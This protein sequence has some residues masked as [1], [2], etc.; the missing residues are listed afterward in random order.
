MR[1]AGTRH[2]QSELLVVHEA[3]EGEE[4]WTDL[5]DLLLRV[6]TTG[7]IPGHAT[8][9]GQVTG[10]T[11]KGGEKFLGKLGSGLVLVRDE[12][13]DVGLATA[14][15]SAHAVIAVGEV[16]L[17]VLVLLLLVALRGGRPLRWVRFTLGGHGDSVEGWFG[18]LV[19]IQGLER[20]GDLK[21][22]RER[23]GISEGL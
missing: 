14:V 9:N 13:L 23:R 22:G 12:H 11:I 16:A 4:S 7:Q 19:E 17:K 18:V 5:L 3:I 2:G 20:D 8:G 10:L 6:T 1:G 21:V 15:S